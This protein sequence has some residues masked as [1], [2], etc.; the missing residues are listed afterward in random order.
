MGDIEQERTFVAHTEDE[1][2][3]GFMSGEVFEASEELA[4]EFGS[5]PNDM[6][7]V[8]STVDFYAPTNVLAEGEW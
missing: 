5:D 6:E 3:P 4:A 2:W 7:N 8:V 1:F